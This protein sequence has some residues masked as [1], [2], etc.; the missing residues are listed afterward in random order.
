MTT[1]EQTLLTAYE[2]A[3][4]AVANVNAYITYAHAQQMDALEAQLGEQRA[5]EIKQIARRRMGI[6]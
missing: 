3:I 5:A 6:A 2:D 1:A 4:T